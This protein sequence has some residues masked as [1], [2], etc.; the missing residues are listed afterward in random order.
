[1]TS[2]RFNYLTFKIKHMMKAKAF[3]QREKSPVFNLVSR[4]TKQKDKM[5]RYNTKYHQV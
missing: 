2:N 4:Q 5:N 3:L 1:M